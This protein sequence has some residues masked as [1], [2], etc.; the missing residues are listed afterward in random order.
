MLTLKVKEMELDSG[1]PLIAVLNL[2]DSGDLGVRSQGRIKILHDTCQVT[3]IVNTTEKVIRKGEIGIYDEVKNNLHLRDEDLVGVTAAPTPQSLNYIRGKLRGRKLSYQEIY[4]IVDDVVHGNLS[5]A[6]VASFVT[7]LHFRGLD[8]EETI[9]ISKAMVET[10][11]TLKLGKEVVVD[12]HSIGG[13]PGDKTTLLVVPIVA[14]CGLTIPKSSS[15][16]ITSAA[17]TADRAETL[18]P[19]ILSIEEMK[20][21]VN[22]ANGCI[23]WGGALELSPA[24][25]IFIKVEFPLSIDPLLLPS[26]LSKKKAVGSN[27]LVVDIPCGWG[28]KIKTLEEAHQLAGEFIELGKRLDIKI[29]CIVTYGSQPIGYTIGPA[30]EAKEALENI[31]GQIWCE[32]LIDKA[33]DIAGSILDMNGF[34]NGKEIALQTLK[35]G[36]AEEKLREIIDLQGGD[37]N[38]QPDDLPIGSSRYDIRSEKQGYLIWINNHA[39]VE[40]ARKAGTPKDKGAGIKLYKKTG[41]TVKNGDL[42]LTLFA[43]KGSKLEDAISTL[44]SSKAMQVGKRMEMTM[45]EVKAVTTEV[46]DFIL[47]R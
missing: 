22:R 10:G 3:A 45:S 2:E 11:K 44:E 28:A 31:M 30:L 14:A 42:L 39:L 20:K 4:E 46:E 23:V 19:V 27:S 26:I 41:D 8:L 9:N 32:D 12:K 34:T 5:D 7:A 43:E 1:G 18:M 33:T 29:R 36:K 38:L 17:G 13:V 35:N 21:V 25:D 6:E 16:A 15:R 40:V 37:T 47:E 24:D